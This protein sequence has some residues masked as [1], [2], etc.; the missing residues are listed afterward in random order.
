MT[1]MAKRGAP[2]D[3]WKIGEG[4]DRIEVEEAV[5]V[6]LTIQT[7]AEKM[8]FMEESGEGVAPE[9]TQDRRALRDLGD[10]QARLDEKEIRDKPQGLEI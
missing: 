10:L 9:A 3:T 5:E 2:A 6:R 8:G 1:P 7:Q 4:P